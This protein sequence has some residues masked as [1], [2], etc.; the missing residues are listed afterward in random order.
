MP[1]PPPRERRESYYGHPIIDFLLSHNRKQ[2]E[3][4]AI[5]ARAL[6]LS[7]S[8]ALVPLSASR[9]TSP[10]AEGARSLYKSQHPT[11]ICALKCMDGRLNLS[12]ITQTPAGSMLKTP[13]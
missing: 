2:S 9:F 4:Y 8:R 11:E 13:T 12:I 5:R 3:L 1:L 6:V 7:C 10:D